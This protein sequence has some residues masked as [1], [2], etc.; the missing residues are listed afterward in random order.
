[1]IKRV[2]T[3]NEKTLM[4]A[5]AEGLQ[6][7]ADG[8]R[9]V[10]FK[11]VSGKRTSASSVR[12]SCI[13]HIETCKKGKSPIACQYTTVDV[14]HS[15]ERFELTDDN[16]VVGSQAT[17]RELRLLHKTLSGS[18]VFNR[19]LRLICLAIDAPVVKYTFRLN[20]TAVKNNANE[21]AWMRSLQVLE[22]DG[23]MT[24]PFMKYHH[25]GEWSCEARLPGQYG[26]SKL[27][28]E[29]KLTIAIAS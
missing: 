21:P 3:V 4:E 9:L 27:A 10:V 6:A 7:Y 8:H 25:E 5:T 12:I 15:F 19:T 11:D 1:M 16:S 22:I 13:V 2:W 24:I 23:Q 18:V 20:G 29:A 28:A 14:L 26:K 17:I